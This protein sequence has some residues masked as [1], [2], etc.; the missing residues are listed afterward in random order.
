VFLTVTDDS[1]AIA[2]ASR[3]VRVLEL[4][5]PQARNA[6]AGNVGRIVGLTATSKCSRQSFR[7][8]RKDRWNERQLTDMGNTGTT[9]STITGR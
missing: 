7:D 5:W 2:T 8:A 9:T 1:N 3:Q 4:R 6:S